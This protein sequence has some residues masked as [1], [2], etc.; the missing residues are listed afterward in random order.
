[1]N[2]KKYVVALMLGAT[3]SVFADNAP[4]Y[5]FLF[6]G[7]GMSVPQRMNADEF[8][9]AAGRGHLAMNT[10]PI[11]AT[12]RTCSANALITDSAAA[13]TAIACGE[14]TNNGAL[15]VDTNKV[16]LES[17]AYVA[18]K[19]GRKIGIATT[20]TIIHATPGGFYAH[21]QN[22]GLSYQ[23]GLDLLNSDFDF[24][25]GGGLGGAA[26]DKKDPNYCGNLYNL[27]PEKGYTLVTNKADFLALKPGCGKIW[28]RAC[29][30]Y[31]QYSI[32][33]D[34]TQ[35]SIAEITAK[36][37]ELL[38][39]PN[40]FF[41]MV[42]GG[43]IDA[44]GHANDAAPNLRDVL[45][46]DDA[47]KVA[48]EFQEKHPD[49]TLV[50]V[51]GDHETGGLTMGFAGTGYAFRMDL[52]ASQK[53]S[54]DA[55]GGH[56]NSAVAEARKELGATNVTFDVAIPVLEKDFGFVFTTN[57]A[58]LAEI[59][60]KTM[61]VRDEERKDLNKAF[62]EGKLPH[63]ARRLMSTKCGIGWSSGGHTS[64][65]VLTTS[66]GKCAEVFTGFM[67]NTDIANRFKKLY[68]E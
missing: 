20:V 51:T 58:E 65:P 2:I 59:K 66:K 47:V 31:M 18:K 21:R 64:L 55:F 26:N 60:D 68:T 8:S 25:A 40:G 15:G 6:I 33:A 39:N 56:L 3:L 35:P 12:T 22:R 38:D 16:A 24:F 29:E 4:K 48:L 43:K 1:M 42:E 36:G 28:M 10:L 46:L 67:E 63:A 37:I 5:V 57:A 54:T 45:A 32:D 14:K 23:I 9:R 53:C 7:D 61:V 17:V 19:A 49:D 13:A 52:L 50:M 62:K 44:A 27:A 34:G 30:G 11:Q 41:F